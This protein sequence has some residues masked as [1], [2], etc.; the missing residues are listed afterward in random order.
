MKLTVPHRLAESA[1]CVVLG[2]IFVASQAG[3]PK[4]DQAAPVSR[5][6]A[7]QN[8]PSSRQQNQAVE[9]ARQINIEDPN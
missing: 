3:N 1:I 7:R 9:P 5:P 8:T 2:W 4:P 6:S